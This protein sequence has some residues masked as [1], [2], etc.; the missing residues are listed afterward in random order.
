MTFKEREQIFSKEIITYK[1]LAILLEVDVC[2]A[3]TILNSIKSKYD[4][5][6]IRGKIHVQDYL[7]YFK[8]NNIERYINPD[9]IN[10]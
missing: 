1:E 2:T 5:L 3:S 4:R 10:N 8:I 9:A 6:H 7:D